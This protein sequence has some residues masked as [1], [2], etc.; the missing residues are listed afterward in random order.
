M[1]TEIRISRLGRHFSGREIRPIR[2]AADNTLTIKQ[3]STLPVSKTRQDKSLFRSLSDTYLPLA[4]PTVC[5]SSAEGASGFCQT[6]PPSGRQLMSIGASEHRTS[7]RAKA[8]FAGQKAQ[9]HSFVRRNAVTPDML[10]CIVAGIF[11]NLGHDIMGRMGR[12]GRR[13]QSTG[14]NRGCRSRPTQLECGQ[15]RLPSAESDGKCRACLAFPEVPASDLPVLIHSRRNATCPVWPS[16]TS[17]PARCEPFLVNSLLPGP[18]TCPAWL[19]AAPASARCEP[20]PVFPLRPGP[21]TCP[22]WPSAASVAAGY[23]PFSANRLT[24]ASRD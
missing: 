13:T 20:F 1:G 8:R 6:M 3:K 9:E 24:P 19:S 2:A 4:N 14:I 17:A 10:P 22:A 5:P 15:R 7:V 12:Y 16:A 23:E 18:S 21:S 11:A